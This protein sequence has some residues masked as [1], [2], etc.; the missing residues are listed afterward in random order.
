MTHLQNADF[1]SGFITGILKGGRDIAFMNA[2]KPCIQGTIELPSDFKDVIKNIA[3]GNLE[4]I[5]K[6]I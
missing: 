6:G 4:G 2:V 3:V 5:V 1:L